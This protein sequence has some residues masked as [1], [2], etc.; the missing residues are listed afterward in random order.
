MGAYSNSFTRGACK[1]CRGLHAVLMPIEDEGDILF[2]LP[3]LGSTMQGWGIR[4]GEHQRLTKLALTTHS[5]I[6]TMAKTEVEWCTMCGTHRR[7]QPRVRVIGD[8]N[9]DIQ[10]LSS[11]TDRQRVGPGARCLEMLDLLIS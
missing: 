2:Q 8:S 6:V 11:S 5:L 9:W 7:N 3:L 1:A 4:G 10:N